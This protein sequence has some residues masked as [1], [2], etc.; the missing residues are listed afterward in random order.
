[1]QRAAIL[2]NPKTVKKLKPGASRE[3]SLLLF[4]NLG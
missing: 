4:G 2:K 3:I 1:M